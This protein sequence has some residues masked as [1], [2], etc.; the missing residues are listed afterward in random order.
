M[1]VRNAYG[2]Q[3]D[4]FRSPVDPGPAPGLEGFE[5]IFIR[6]PML[7]GLGPGV[8]VLARVGG[9]PVLVR[10]ANVWAATFH[11]EL[12][13]DAR[14]HREWLGLGLPATG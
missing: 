1:A 11:P 3:V 14:V 4:S 10:Q 5:C 8:E 12:G 9:R 6:A 7:E 13:E 2:T